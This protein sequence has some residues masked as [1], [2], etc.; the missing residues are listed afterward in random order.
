MVKER[1]SGPGFGKLRE[2]SG[3]ALVEFAFVLL[4]MVVLILGT[5]DFARAYLQYQIITDA[6]REGARRA[7]V[8]DNT[9]Q[10]EVFEEILD[11]LRL[12]GINAQPD[13]S[14]LVVDH[15]DP[16]P[17]GATRVNVYE[18]DWNAATGIPARVGIAVPFEF[19]L[20]GPMIGWATGDRRITLRTTFSMRNE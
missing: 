9:S 19:A 17:S 1:R 7:V 13:N 14:T 3:Q 15:C 16:P 2:E 18:C 10:T 5:V 4:M 20:V 6:A 12:G 11:W 8:A